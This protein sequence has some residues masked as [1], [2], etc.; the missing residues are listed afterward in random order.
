MG[1]KGFF[2][3]DEWFAF[4]WGAF[5][6]ITAYVA[7]THTIS[8]ALVLVAAFALIYSWAQRVLSLH[9]R[10]WRRKVMEFQ[11]RYYVEG[12]GSVVPGTVGW[13]PGHD[14][15]RRDIIRPAEVTLK[16]MNAG[17]ILIAVGLLLMRV[18]GPV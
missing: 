12:E 15:T 14:L 16:L 3:R 18:M 10:L 11:G 7:Q 13:N 1:P 17:I 6:A 8:A 2:H 9:A 5:P 4:A